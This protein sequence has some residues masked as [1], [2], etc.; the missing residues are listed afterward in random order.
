MKALKNQIM[1]WDIN[2]K[3]GTSNGK[4]SYFYVDFKY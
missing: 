3:F 4:Y 1:A 2:Y